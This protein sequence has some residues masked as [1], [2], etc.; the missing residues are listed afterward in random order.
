MTKGH[1]RLLFQSLKCKITKIFSQ[2]TP[3]Q[4]M[5]TVEII[6]LRDGRQLGMSKDSVTVIEYPHHVVLVQ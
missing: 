5:N 6:K 1:S 2:S 3:G 4:A